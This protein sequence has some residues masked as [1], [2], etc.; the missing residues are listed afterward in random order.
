MC[1]SRWRPRPGA[2]RVC[3]CLPSPQTLCLQKEKS[4]SSSHRG[5]C[6]SR[7]HVGR[8][9]GMEGPAGEGSGER[10]GH[11]CVLSATGHSVDH[12]CHG[13]LAFYGTPILGVQAAGCLGGR[14]P[15]LNACLHALCR[16][17]GPRETL[18]APT[19]PACHPSGGD[20]LHCSEVWAEKRHSGH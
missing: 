5:G 1:P 2:P 16:G 3:A 9:S 8:T 20:I 4:S 15:L 14:P 17:G 19:D 13:R 11:L 18:G 10:G 7:G 6:P 12:L